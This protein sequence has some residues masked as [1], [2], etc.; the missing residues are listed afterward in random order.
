MAQTSVSSV[1]MTEFA[2][3]GRVSRLGRSAGARAKLVQVLRS[4]APVG[5]SYFAAGADALVI[6]A[7]AYCS[8]VFYRLATFGLMPNVESVAQVGAVV[9]LIVVGSGLQRNEYDLQQYLR[10]SGQ[11]ERAFGVWNLAFMVVLTLGFATKQSSDFSRAAM[12]VFYLLGYAG[13]VSA[14]RSM[15]DIASLMLAR[16]FIEPRRLIIVGFEDRLSEIESGGLDF[17]PGFDVVNM[18]ALRDN[19]AYLAD[20]LSLASAAVR[21]HRADDIC[22]AA[23]WSRQDIIGA[24]TA[25]F[26]RTPAELHLDADRLLEQFSHAHF[27]RLGT[28][29]GLRITRPKL[30]L[31]QR[32]E[33]RTFDILAAGVGLLLLSPLLALIAILIRIESPGPALF[34]Q[35]RY[36]FNQEPFSVFKFRSM[37][38]MENGAKVVAATRDDPRVTRLGR[39]LRRLSL[40]ELPQLINV[41]RGE[42]SIVGPRPHAMAHDQ[43]YFDRLS[44]YARRHNVKPGI[45]GWAQVHGHRGEIVNDQQM[46]S[47]LEHDLYYVDNWSLWLDIKIVFM[48]VLSSKA[49]ANAF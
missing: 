20:D 33:K 49:H 16:R 22:L 31:L 6:F 13:L 19:Q 48:T 36:G 40:D 25:A 46:L 47:R 27:S 30:S 15:V 28:M 42:M 43:R 9:A 23:P 41:L 21:M 1:S 37:S 29:S 8:A 38:T 35:T 4:C 17:G 11:T 2:S 14:R 44:R 34:R 3:S 24:A 12:A 10:K 5:F 26:L 32:I 39:H 7:A 18:F 45:T